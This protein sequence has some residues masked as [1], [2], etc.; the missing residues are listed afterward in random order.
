MANKNKYLFASNVRSCFSLFVQKIALLS[1]PVLLLL[2]PFRY[3]ITSVKGALILKVSPRTSSE[4]F[5]RSFFKF[6]V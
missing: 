6:F 4:V 2:T 1:F 5:D 3:V